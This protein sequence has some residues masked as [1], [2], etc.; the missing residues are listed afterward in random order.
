MLE[1][2]FFVTILVNSTRRKRHSMD[3]LSKELFY[4][5]KFQRYKLSDSIELNFPLKDILI[6]LRTIIK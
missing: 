3:Y 6:I 2:F 4:Y 1:C 5:I